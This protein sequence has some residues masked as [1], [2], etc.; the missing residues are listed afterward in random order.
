MTTRM[1]VALDVAD[2]ARSI[3]FYARLF[4]LEPARRFDDYAKFELED[5]PL[6]L[7]LNPAAAAPSGAQRLSHLGVRVAG[8]AELAALRARLAAAGFAP[9][10]ERGTACCYAYADKLWLSDPDGNEWELYQ[11]LGDAPARYPG[12]GACCAPDTGADAVPSA[13]CCSPR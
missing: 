9:R 10:E 11:R 8:A 12:D 4:G 7:S 2:L 6:V 13:A 5:P 1:H 3:D